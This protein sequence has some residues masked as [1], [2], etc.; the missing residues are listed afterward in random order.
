MQALVIPRFDYGSAT[1]C[2]PDPGWLLWG[3]SSMLLQG[4]SLLKDYHITPDL[5][6]PTKLESN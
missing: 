5:K 4:S 2:C 1:L 6:S 3:L